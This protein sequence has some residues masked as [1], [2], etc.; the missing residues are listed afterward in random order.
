MIEHQ[1]MLTWFPFIPDYLQAQ[2]SLFNNSQFEISILYSIIRGQLTR[3]S[4][5]CTVPWV[6]LY[7][8]DF[9]EAHLTVNI[10]SIFVNL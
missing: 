7:P 10:S 6:L 5:S 3:I 8:N 4:I 2:I 1:L 9:R